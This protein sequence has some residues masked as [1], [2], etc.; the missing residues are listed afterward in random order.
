MIFLRS[1]FLAKAGDL[2]NV[3]EIKRVVPLVNQNLLIIWWKEDKLGVFNR[4]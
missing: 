4:N 2:K 3:D 1:S